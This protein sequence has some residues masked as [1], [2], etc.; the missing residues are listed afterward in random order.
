MRT[1]HASPR[2]VANIVLTALF[3]SITSAVA[4]AQTTPD[5]SVGLTPYQSFHG[6]DIDSV[7]LSNG[8]LVLDIPIIAYPQRGALK[9]SFSLVYNSKNTHSTQTCFPGS[10]PRCVRFWFYGIGPSVMDKGQVGIM[11]QIFQSPNQGPKLSE[12]AVTTPD[13]AQH[14]ILLNYPAVGQIAADGTGFWVNSSAVTTVPAPTVIIDRD[15][16]RHYITPSTPGVISEDPNGNQIKIGTG[17]TITDTMGRVFLPSGGP[18]PGSPTTNFSGCTGP[19][20]IA[21]ATIWSLPGVSGGTM[22]YKFCQVTVAISIPAHG[23]VP[24]SSGNATLLQSIVLPN[25]TAWTFEYND[26]DPTDP[27]TINYGTMTKITLPTGGTISYVYTTGTGMP[28][29]SYPSYAR[30]VTSRT[31]NANDGS[32]PHAWLYNLSTNTVTDPLGDDVVHTF[33][34][35]GNPACTAF[36]TKT[37]SYQGSSSSGTL[38]KTVQTDYNNFASGNDVFNAPGVAPIRVT[39]TWPNGQVTKVETDYDSNGPGNVPYGNVIAKREYDYGNGSP[40]PLLRKTNAAYMAFSGPNAS[41]YL[42]NN[43]LSIPYT[44]QVLNGPG[45]LAFTQ[46]NYDE[47]ALGNSGVGSSEQHDTAPPAGTYRGNE[48]SVLRWLNSGTMTCPNGQ[49][50][51]SGSNVTSKLTYF[52]TG[53]LQT[54]ADPCGNT[55]TDAYSNIY[56]GAFPTT[57]TN[58]LSQPTNHA[59]DFNT[60]LLTSS[61]DP[62]NLVTSYAYD[63]MWRLASVAAPDG[64]V[65]TI[66]HQESSFPFTATLTKPINASLQ[67]ETITNVFDGAG[68]LTQS[69]LTSDPQGTV[70][71]DTAYDALGRVATVSN[72]YRS[73]TDITTTT[74]T[75]TYGYDAISRK[76]SE[77][78][79]DNS[80]LTTAYCGPSTLVTDPTRRWRRSRTD[81][82]GQLVEV[83][84]PNA[85]GAT[86]AS[87]GCPGTGEPIWV[88]SYGYD[89]LGNLLSV[90]QNGSHSRTFTYDSFSRLLTSTNP[91]VGTITYTYNPDSP[92]L[93]K[94]DARSIT[95]TYL[96]DGLHRETVTSRSN[97]DPTITTVYDGS[98]CLGLSA[99]QN[100]GRRTSMTDATGSES[101]SFDVADRIHK[102]QRTTSSITKSTTYNLDLAGN[103]TSVVYPT[104]RAVNYTYDSA[105]RPSSATDSANG[106]TYATGFTTSPG[107][108][109]LTNVT[110]Y[111]PQGTFYG[112]SIGQ[113]SSFTGVNLT[114]NYNSR[115]QPNEFKASSTA[116]NAID[117]TYSYADPLNSNKNAGHVFSITNNLDSTRSQTF[118][119]DQLN[120]ITAAQTTSTYATSPAHCWAE[121]YSLDPW[122]NL[123]SLAGGNS[124]YTG[125]MYE[126]GFSKTPDGNNHLSG[127]TY[128]V[129]GNTASDGFNSYT[130]DAESQLKVTAGSTYLYDGD[131]RRVAKANTAVPPV[132]YKLYWYGSGGDILAE[133]DGSGNTTAEYI[134]FGGKRIATIGNGIQNG[135]FEQ[136]LSG[137][138]TTGLSGGTVQLINNPANAHSGN[139]YVDLSA[140]AGG[141]AYLANSS[142]PVHP[143]DQVTFGGW[144]YLESGGSSWQPGWW[145]G[146]QDAN[147]SMFNWI[148]PSPAAS[149]GWTYQSGTY[150]VPSSGVAYVVLYATVYQ[151]TSTTAMRVD[152]GFI[153]VGANYYVEDMLGTSRVITQ[154]NGTVCYDADFYPYGGERA[155]YTNTCTQNYK[156]EGKER[157]TETGNDDFGARYY[158]NRFGRWLSADWSS[159]PVPVPYANLTNPQTFSLYSLVADDPES[160]AD[161]NGH[162]APYPDDTPHRDYVPHGACYDGR[163]ILGQDGHHLISLW[164][165]IAKGPALYWIKNVLKTGP[166]ADE[167]KNY[168]N[169]LHRLYNLGVKDIVTQMQDELGKDISQFSRKE[170]AE[171]AKR[172]LTSKN[173][174]IQNF[175]DSLGQ[176][177]AGQSARQALQFGADVVGGLVDGATEIVL[178][179]VINTKDPLRK[180]DWN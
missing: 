109:C 102:E 6:G 80:V 117:I 58:A 17:G 156:F 148:S 81:G 155:P 166:L 160:F 57:V 38:L 114:H 67:N 110:C 13:G 11:E 137:W 123:Q 24:A 119:Y 77:T 22:Q 60:G 71:T 131:G 21:S 15:G 157:D 76:V 100:I 126:T 94:K 98:N 124:Q 83:D 107:G 104:G 28:C 122:G 32:G 128:D 149:S 25:G 105:N 73:G 85:V 26:R 62:N 144:V 27:A 169:A 162:Y 66:T 5:S 93:T 134:F 44:V 146:I 18:A 175:I 47:S 138:S 88:T 56:W 34:L 111:T 125:C 41:S 78:Y 151:N 129:S 19:L 74:G 89:A 79:P 49:S 180:D 113:T 54:S 163:C 10:P 53:M 87:T 55:T 161:L 120:R 92:V 168:Y 103:I 2:A 90:L 143:G 141:Y 135:G 69:R 8:N 43:L 142:I 118:S 20:P 164:D 96:Y 174:A 112:L 158:S 82:L 152:D 3:L 39:T 63:N 46:Y 97:G 121:T 37:Q 72:P 45:S 153:Q 130:W 61:T 172:V 91:E 179:F 99:C 4:K 115:L 50:A 178:P 101:W 84:E 64:G 52:D 147:H 35:F 173:A 1:S 139:Y 14:P 51:G 116:G 65:T 150:T 12:F 70:Y 154:N 48:T 140:P 40:G 133:T 145:L 33:T 23:T 171:L 9:M 7:N 59:Y 167:T 106:V 86:V 127:L 136:G 108:T 16:V 36:E 29:V 177:R 30:L 68:R 95:T 159:T 75:T 42:A 31:V 170:V 132:P 176:T 165:K